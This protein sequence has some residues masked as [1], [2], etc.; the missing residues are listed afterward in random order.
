VKRINNYKEKINYQAYWKHSNMCD[1]IDL[2]TFKQIS[3]KL[4]VTT[5]KTPYSS[6]NNVIV[7]FLIAYQQPLCLD[8]EDGQKEILRFSYYKCNIKR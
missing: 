3:Q 8:L 7:K 6:N 5:N 1:D 4:C 2:H